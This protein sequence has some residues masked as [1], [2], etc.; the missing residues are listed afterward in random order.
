AY[1]AIVPI[2]IEQSNQ[3]YIT[4]HNVNFTEISLKFLAAMLPDKTCLYEKALELYA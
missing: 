1:V 4:L 3:E 2:L